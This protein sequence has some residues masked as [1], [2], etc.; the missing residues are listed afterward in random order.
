MKNHLD[1]RSREGGL[2]GDDGLAEEGG[3]EGGLALDRGEHELRELPA[4]ARREVERRHLRKTAS[5]NI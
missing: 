4:R 3:V 1:R 2:G 5:E